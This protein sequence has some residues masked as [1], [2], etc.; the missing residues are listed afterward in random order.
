MPAPFQCLAV[1]TPGLEAITAAEL[2]ALRLTPG[3]S[4]PGGVSFVAHHSGI[5]R[6]NLELRTATRVLVR[7][8]RFHAHSFFEL[9]R[10]AGEIPWEDWLPP[11]AEP[12]FRVTSRKSK[13]YHQDA[14]AERLLKAAGRE[15]GK[16]AGPASTL[17]PSRPSALFV[18]RLWRDELTLSVDASGEALHR[19]GYRLETAKAPL[20]E[21]LGAAMLL[22]MA[23]D[24]SAPLI[25]PFCGSGTIPIEAAL[26]ARRMAPGRRRPFAFERWPRFE[27]ATW[28]K[29][30]HEAEAKV[31][32]RVPAPI[33]G[34]DRDAGAVEASRAN[35]MRAGVHEDATFE[36]KA[37]SDLDYG[38]SA[39]GWVV[40][41]PPYG[42][43]IGDRRELRDLYARLGQVLAR[44]PPAWRAAILSAYRE[45]E[46]AAG[47]DWAE[48]L[49]TTNGG[50][51]VRLMEG[52]R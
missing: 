12:V 48:I 3:E 36:R 47:I 51:G 7:V 38:N 39:A 24:G 15:G 52:G 26:I 4:E 19:R 42:V 8:A 22:A 31:L 17:P 34:S 35:A 5:Y 2:A 10:H 13:L 20:R 11:G 9:E 45:L 33:L 37:L 18:A 23:Y 29:V 6:A 32:D 44:R 14:V 16:A 46:R 40:T 30:K 25:D 43:R 28:S 21:T 1:T 41:N 50:L 27:P 49:E